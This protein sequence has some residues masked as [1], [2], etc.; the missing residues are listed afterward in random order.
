M[1]I[2]FSL[3]PITMYRIIFLLSLFFNDCLLFGQNSD[4][5]KSIG[6]LMTAPDS[7]IYLANKVLSSSETKDYAMAHYLIGRAN[8]NKGKN[9]EAK[10]SLFKALELAEKV[11]DLE[12]VFETRSHLGD[13]YYRM[14]NHDSAVFY[15]ESAISLIQP[16]F[17]S[18][19][20]G[21]A[22]QLLANVFI[23]LGRLED[24][25][26]GYIDALGYFENM[27]AEVAA[28]K[29]YNNLGIV[30]IYLKDFNKALEYFEQSLAIKLKRNDAKGASATYNNMGTV[31][32]SYLKDSSKAVDY[33][34]KSIA[35]KKEIGDVVGAATTEVNLGHLL[36]KS[37]N[38]RRA[39]QYYERAIGIFSEANMP[40]EITSTYTEIGSNYLDQ[41]NLIKAK[42]F[43]YKARETPC[44]QWDKR[45]LMQNHKITAEVLKRLFEYELAL[46]HLSEYQTLYD[47]IFQKERL[48]FRE[49]LIE[50]YESE[51]KQSE[52]DLLI[53]ESELQEAIIDRSRL[54]QYAFLGATLFAVAIGI[55]F[56]SRYRIKKRSA[57]DKETL[58]KE[59]HHRVKNNLQIIESLLSLQEANKGDMKPEELLKIS[60]DRIHAI[61]AIHEKL[62]HSEN[63]REINFKNY[64]EDLVT[65][66]SDSFG[67]S[68]VSFRADVVD[69]KMDL[70]QLIPC[71]LIINELVTNSLK[72]AFVK[73][74][75]PNI[76]INGIQE[77]G[78]Y[79][80]E[81]GDNGIGF[82][83]KERSQSL[84]LRLVQSL[85][86]Q[87]DGT[88]QKIGESGTRYRISFNL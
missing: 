11:S 47:S 51:K 66:F 69:T 45:D 13:V 41:D 2:D 82:Q 9:A 48:E 79:H 30:S 39:T 25:T 60:Q 32:Y 77:K 78:K 4:L 44:E 1:N 24:A 17:D 15:H 56:Y 8:I 19:K 37:G 70:D 59:I 65:H 40:S 87:L 58:L 12:R 29:V 16:D 85:V 36:L 33:F 68:S 26:K 75:D 5:N 21:N 53:K 38:E 35:I 23:T 49:E 62:Y 61:S 67:S 22:H 27:G 18:L 55:L 3:T 6:L 64:I 10:M 72:Y 86:T 14:S 83:E 76:E 57:E 28:S 43:L 46:E 74:E 20:V 84:G 31:A 52:I 73:S 81:I 7:S 54:I 63:L 71:G 50:K 42:Y 34:E 80:L 88:I